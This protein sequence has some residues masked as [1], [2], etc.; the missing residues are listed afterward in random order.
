MAASVLP[1]L[2]QLIICTVPFAALGVLAGCGG[3]EGSETALAPGSGPSSPSPGPVNIRPSPPFPPVIP[4]T[5]RIPAQGDLM[6]RYI[7]PLRQ[8]NV[9]IEGPIT[10]LD[11]D[12]G[13]F[14]VLTT[15]LRL[16]ANT[17]IAMES[18]PAAAGSLADLRLGDWVR[19]AAWYEEQSV[20][21]AVIAVDA[22]PGGNE[23][24]RL[25]APIAGMTAQGNTLLALG[26]ALVIGPDTRFQLNDHAVSANAFFAGADPGGTLTA[27]GWYTGETL[28]AHRISASS[29]SAP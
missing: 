26:T 24:A 16:H 3:E 14:M 8:I 21:A 4:G 18:L 23:T 13:Q 27:E 22:T 29:H 28:W 17:A 20:L 12:S 9:L 2:R 11:A 5:P 25:S 10:A 6:A 7:A 1:L 15:P 19:V